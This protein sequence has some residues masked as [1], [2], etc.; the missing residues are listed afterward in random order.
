[1]SAM[2]VEFECLRRAPAAVGGVAERRERALARLQGRDDFTRR[3]VEHRLIEGTYHGDLDV[4]AAVDAQTL[5]VVV[6]GRGA[7]R[8][9]SCAALEAPGVL[10]VAQR[11]VGEGGLPLAMLELAEGRSRIRVRLVD[12]PS[13][14][15]SALE[16]ECVAAW[17]AADVAE[18]EV[19]EVAPQVLERALGLARDGA[20]GDSSRGTLL[21]RAFDTSGDEASRREAQRAALEAARLDIL[22]LILG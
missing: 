10:C 17:F 14:G 6:E 4:L 15:A 1:M 8:L 18:V 19:A 12:A 2:P 21:A 3:C 5:Y 22:A 16:A 13:A 9:V 7:Q 20:L 11:A